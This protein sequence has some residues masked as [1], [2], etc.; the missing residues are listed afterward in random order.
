MRNHFIIKPFQLI[1][2]LCSVG[3]LA[4]HSLDTILV[5]NYLEK[6]NCNEAFAFFY[7]MKFPNNMT[8]KY[9]L[10]KCIPLVPI[11]QKSVP[12]RLTVTVKCLRREFRTGQK[13]YKK[14]LW[15]IW[16]NCWTTKRFRKR[17]SFFTLFCFI[18]NNTAYYSSLKTNET[19][20]EANLKVLYVC[21]L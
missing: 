12:T 3:F 6:I 21:I 15:L 1:F 8:Q 17:E 4:K 20:I 9:I 7:K 13:C 14:D 16:N 2:S 5:F 10:E 18:A 11:D 19:N